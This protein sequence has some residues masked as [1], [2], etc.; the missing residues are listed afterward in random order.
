[1][2]KLNWKQKLFVVKT[3]HWIIGCEVFQETKKCHICIRDP[4][5]N[6][7]DCELCTSCD[8]CLKRITQIK[9]YSTE[10]NKWKGLPPNKHGYMLPHY[11]GEEE[12][13]EQEK[14]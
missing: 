14:E 10:I 3:P 1:M 4:M 9:Y 13:K 5:L 8:K 2:S 12:E 6:C 11:I 7:F